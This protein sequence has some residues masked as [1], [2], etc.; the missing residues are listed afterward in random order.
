MYRYTLTYAYML[1]YYTWDLYETFPIR[2]LL[3]NVRGRELK[4][5]GDFWNARVAVNRPCQQRD[6]IILR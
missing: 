1:T 2:N 6:R 3:G 5:A 4:L